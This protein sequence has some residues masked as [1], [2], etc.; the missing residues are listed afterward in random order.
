LHVEKLLRVVG[1]P[2]TLIKSDMPMPAATADAAT[3]P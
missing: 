1:S 3:L 2:A